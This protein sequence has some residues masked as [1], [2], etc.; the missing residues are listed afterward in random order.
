MGPPATSM[1]WPE[2][3]LAPSLTRKETA[4]ATS[5]GWPTRPTGICL[6]DRLGAAYVHTPQDEAKQLPHVAAVLVRA[7]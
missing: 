5:A 3:K 4:W 2:T 6:G 1:T 7:R